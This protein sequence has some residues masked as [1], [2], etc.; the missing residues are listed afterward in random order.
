MLN[1]RRFLIS[2]S[3]LSLGALLGFRGGQADILPP[4]PEYPFDFQ[5]LM[6]IAEQLAAH[7]YQAPPIRSAEV[8]EGIDFDTYQKIRFKAEHALW[9][10]TD[11]PFAVEL[12]MPGR[13]FKAPVKIY[14]L[15]QGIAREINYRPELF[16]FADTGLAD[17]LP[18]DLGFAGFRIMNSATSR[19][20]WLAFQGASYFR[21]A[22]E[23]NQYGLS[24]RGIAINTAMPEPEEFPRFTAFWLERPAAGSDR[25]TLY[26]L[27][28]GPSLA[29]A[30]RF[31][32]TK[33]KGVV[34]EIQAELFPRTTIARLGVA[35]LTSMFWYGENNR[36]QAVD[37]RPE[38]HD[39][40][41]LAIHG[42]TGERIWRPLINPPTVRT[43][44]FLDRA[45]KGFG[46][47]QRDR[48]FDHHQDDGAFYDRRP[49]VWVEPLSD[50]GSGAVQLV[51]IPTDG[52]IHD[53]IV[54]YW[55]PEAP[56]AAGSHHAFHYRLHWLAEEPYPAHHVG[57]AVA[58]RIGRGGMPGQDPP[59]ENTRKFVIDF[60]GGPLETLAQRYDVMPIVTA[61]RGAVERPYALKVVGTER[62]RAVFDLKLEG[63]APV[64][65]RCFL[66]LDG[67]TLTETWLYQYIPQRY[68]E[69]T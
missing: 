31:V 26:A 56:V 39:S 34:M 29:G 4:D 58:T 25:I 69:V 50:W 21:S 6:A 43:N 67:R 17:K 11:A 37:W 32:C 42:G 24:A 33:K 46:L 38:I 22:G 51:E 3:A 1:R 68:C 55:L 63:D 60:Q 40:D 41:G 15:E 54:A 30:Y 35:P 61:S 14:T 23:L 13:Y 66:R 5:K 28:D 9:H 49:S 47:L 65:L 20:D 7:P 62:W 27:L 57:H 16:D 64:D 12:F 36:R 10:A 53:N 45:P 2:T 19:Q 44:S 18:A 48:D 8:L 59:P 52:E